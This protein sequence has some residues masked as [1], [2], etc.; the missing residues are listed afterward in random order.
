MV[1]YLLDCPPN[2]SYPCSHLWATVW[3][4]KVAMSSHH[5]L[6]EKP[7]FVLA[8]LTSYP[9]LRAI[10]FTIGLVIEASQRWKM[11]P[12]YSPSHHNT[13]RYTLHHLWSKSN[14]MLCQM[15]QILGSVSKMYFPFLIENAKGQIDIYL[16]RG[17]AWS[18]VPIFNH[19]FWFNTPWE[20]N[21]S[22]GTETGTKVPL[23]VHRRQK[24]LWKKPATALVV[25]P[26][27]DWGF[28]WH[29]QPCSLP[30]PLSLPNYQTSSVKSPHT[31]LF[32]HS[33]T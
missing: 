25:E 5:C 2:L 4:I 6:L 8:L 23:S 18:R 1:L 12:L 27:Q 15:A 13:P 22:T 19:E 28:Y 33:W 21:C 7:W 14:K 11:N 29:L 3:G 16:F 17:Y 32:L 24:K 31:R 20:Y 9:S 30:S 26:K 10:R